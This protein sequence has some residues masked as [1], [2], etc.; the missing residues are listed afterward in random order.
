MIGAGKAEHAMVVA[1][2]IENNSVDGGH[3]LYGLGETGS[4]VMLGRAGDT[5]GFGR[6]VFHNHPEYGQALATYFQ[7]REGQSW[8]QVDRDP[9]LATHYL[10]CIPA[11]VEELLKLEEVDCSEIAAVFPPYLTDTDRTELAARLNIPS[12]RFVDLAADA[13]PF[14][15]CLPQ[16]LQ[17]A[18]RQ[19]LVKPGDV[20]LIISVGSGIQVGCATYRF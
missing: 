13:D 5:E 6:F 17:Q 14:S 3:R 4:A 2:E 20:A 7:H 15:S 10:D 11:A 12:S 18:R 9:N 19:G 16:A 8:L 1:S